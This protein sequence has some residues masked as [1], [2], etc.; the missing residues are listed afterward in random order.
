M[1]DLVN[2]V[3]WCRIPV[4]L[5]ETGNRH[6]R[7]D[8]ARATVWVEAGKRACMKVHCIGGFG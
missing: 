4:W 1:A 5:T 7:T 2:L 3:A 8:P 6:S